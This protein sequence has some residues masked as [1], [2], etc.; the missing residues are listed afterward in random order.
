MTAAITMLDRILAIPNKFDR[1]TELV[2]YAKSLSADPVA[3]HKGGDCNE[4][5]LVLLIYDA[6]KKGKGRR[7]RD[8]KM[9]AIGIFILAGLVA[10]IGMVP[11]I[12][13]ALFETEQDAQMGQ[14]KT[15]QAFD[16][17]G[18]PL[19]EDNQP[20]LY[21]L[22]DGVYN[23]PAAGKDVTYQYTY[24]M[25]TLIDKKT[26]DKNGKVIAEDNYRK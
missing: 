23:E 21:K 6:A 12:F 25:G 3:A 15:L 5:M 4:E 13:V 1:Q 22:M 18:K 16:K 17:E 20:V 14:G 10:L 7:D 8:L 26:I 9:L 2:K 24:E 11:K 19:I